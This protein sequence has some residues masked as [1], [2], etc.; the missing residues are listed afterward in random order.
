MSNKASIA[1]AVKVYKERSVKGI[2][3]T[4][5]RGLNM[6]CGKHHG[7]RLGEFIVYAG[8]AHNFK[9]SMLMH[10]AIWAVEYN[11]PA[12]TA[13][14]KPMILIFSLENEAYQN[15]MYWFENIYIRIHKQLPKNMSDE[16]IIEC[17]HNYFETKG[18]TLIIERYFTSTFG[19]EEMVAVIEK[20][21]SS[22][23]DI[24]LIICDTLSQMRKE[25]NK[26]KHEQL[27]ILFNQVRNYTNGN[28]ITFITAHH[29]NRRAAEIA[30]ISPNPVASFNGEHFANSIDVDREPDLTIFIH[31]QLNDKKQPF[32]TMKRGKHRHV[33]DTPEAHKYV[34]YPLTELGLVD[35][36]AGKFAGTRD[37]YSYGK[38]KQDDATQTDGANIAL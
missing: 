2:L 22:G 33:N 37:I 31:I 14:G 21:K 1:K 7:Y 23:F 15:L 4:G 27:Q 30:S 36:V 6:M 13:A 18:F 16:D 20:Y 11:Q 28:G 19:Y 10:N 32:L 26:P 38:D 34:A 3:K 9:S 5:L 25:P 24:R 12:T 29:L 35:D 17:V 8:L